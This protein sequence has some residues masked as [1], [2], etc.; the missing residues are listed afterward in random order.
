MQQ[1]ASRG[2]YYIFLENQFRFAGDSNKPA[3]LL[4]RLV[5]ARSG[6]A[7]CA[8]SRAK[9]RATL[10]NFVGKARFNLTI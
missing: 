6:V 9:P 5:G 10:P 7:G 1:A 2:K 4:S 3:A 8:L